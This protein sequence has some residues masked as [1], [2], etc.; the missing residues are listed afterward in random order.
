[1]R[2]IT[3][4]VLAGTVG[5]LA[6]GIALVLAVD[7][8]MAPEATEPTAARASV[9][10]G[11]PARDAPWGRDT[12]RVQPEHRRT[13]IAEPLVGPGIPVFSPPLATQRVVPPP[14]EHT[15]APRIL[16]P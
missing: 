2:A 11:A 10:A 1:M 8:P 6:A 12:L 4:L 16:P 7:Q 5:L 3:K 13:R 9:I 15:D 14:P